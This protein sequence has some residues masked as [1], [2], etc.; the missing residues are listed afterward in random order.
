[1]EFHL[2]RLNREGRHTHLQAE[3]F[4]TWLRESYQVKEET[5]PPPPFP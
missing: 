4:K 3:N 5:A 2:M 1:M